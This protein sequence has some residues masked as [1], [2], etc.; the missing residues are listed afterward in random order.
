VPRTVGLASV[1]VMLFHAAIAA[2]RREDHKNVSEFSLRPANSCG[3]ACFP[4]DR[5]ALLPP[6]A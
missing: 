5:H 2:M 3:K 4:V 6:P 1:L